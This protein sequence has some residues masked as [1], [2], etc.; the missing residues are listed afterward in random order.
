MLSHIFNLPSPGAEKP[1]GQ[2][3]IRPTIRNHSNLKRDVVINTIA[4]LV[5]D[6]R[7]KVN[8]SSPDKV[9]LVDVYQVSKSISSANK[10]RKSDHRTTC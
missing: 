6:D 5:N 1:W 7:H 4:A 10:Q 3:A 2:F 9:I 8:L